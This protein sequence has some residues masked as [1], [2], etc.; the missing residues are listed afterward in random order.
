MDREAAVSVLL[1]LLGLPW[2][3]WFAFN[4]YKSPTFEEWKEKR[5]VVLAIAIGITFFSL[6]RAVGLLTDYLNR[7]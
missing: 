4:G 3:Y 7:S 1:A 6:L 2:L 5:W